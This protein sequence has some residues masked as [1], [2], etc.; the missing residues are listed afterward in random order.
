[1]SVWIEDKGNLAGC[2][3]GWNESS[4]SLDGNGF[5]PVQ[6][7]HDGVDDSLDDLGALRV[8]S[9]ELPVLVSFVSSNA[10]QLFDFVG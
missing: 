4:E 6:A 2:S 8:T 10:Q 9:E 7:I 5:S 3:A 1:M